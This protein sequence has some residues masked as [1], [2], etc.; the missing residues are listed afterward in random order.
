MRN[1]EQT[2]D[3]GRPAYGR[4]ISL[5]LMVRNLLFTVVVSGPWRRVAAL[6][7]PNA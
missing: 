3:T 2:G 1:I 6:A 5:S 4:A 7:Q